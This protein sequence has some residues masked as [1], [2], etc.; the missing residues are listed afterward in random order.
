M[1]NTKNV[2]RD[3]I[4]VKKT[5]LFGD[6]SVLNVSVLDKNFD[7]LSQFVATGSFPERAR[8]QENTTAATVVNETPTF[9]A[10]SAYSTA[11]MSTPQVVP[12]IPA[13]PAVHTEAVP[14]N[15]TYT[16]TTPVGNAPWENSSGFNRPRR[17]Q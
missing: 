11:P 10:P 12:E 4:Y 15:R 8:T 2:Y 7:E 9:V 1:P 6:F 16:P 3:D 5:D 17:Y 14:A 13:A